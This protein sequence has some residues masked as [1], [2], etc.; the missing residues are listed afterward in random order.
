MAAPYSVNGQWNFLGT[1]MVQGMPVTT[2]I[3]NAVSADAVGQTVAVGAVTTGAPGS[4]AVVTN[5]GT[6]TSP[7]LNFTIPAGATGPAGPAGPVG[8]SPALSAGTATMLPAGSVPTIGLSTNGN[9]YAINVGVPAGTP[10]VSPTINFS[11]VTTASPGSPAAVLDTVSGSTHNISL[12]LPAGA[13]G[14][15]GAPGP[16]GVSPTLTFAPVITANPDTPAS[17]VDTLNGS[18]HTIALTIP[19]GANGA[20]GAAGA[21]GAAG[22]PGNTTAAAFATPYA[23]A[24]RSETARAAD[25]VNVVDYGA[26]GSGY[27]AQ[28]GT[29]YGSTL[30][31]MASWKAADGTTPFT[32]LTSDDYHG[33]VVHTLPLDNAQIAPGTDLNFLSSYSG[34][35]PGTWSARIAQWQRPD[36]QQVYIEGGNAWNVTVAGGNTSTC[37]IPPGTTVSSID[38]ALGD[39]N[40][41][42]ITLSAATTLACP[43]GTNITFTMSDARA[44]RIDPDWLAIESAM[45]V[46][47]QN[48][49]AGS[50][51]GA[52]ERTVM[53]PS[54]ELYPQLPL[55][56]YSWQD[57]PGHQIQI[58]GQGE[59]TSVI[60][61]LVDFGPG[62][63]GLSSYTVSSSAMRPVFR[64]FSMLGSGSMVNNAEGTMSWKMDGLCLTQSAQVDHVISNNFHAGFSWLGDHQHVTNSEAHDNLYGIYA[65]PFAGTLGNQIFENDILTGNNLASFGVASTN[66][67]DSATFTDVHTGF[68]PYGFLKEAD[69]STIVSRTGWC[70]L[71]QSTI[72]DVWAEATGNGWMYDAAGNGC[73]HDNVFIGMHGNSTIQYSNGSGGMEALPGKAKALIYTNSFNDN[74]MIGT[75]WYGYSFVTD[76]VIESTGDCTDNKIIGDNALVNNA[77]W[78]VPPMLCAGQKGGNT[79]SND[80]DGFLAPFAQFV[81]YGSPVTM[82]G[83]GTM[84]GFVTG[85]AFLGTSMDTVGVSGQAQNPNALYPVV[86]SGT[87]VWARL[88]SNSPSANVG[89]MLRPVTGGFTVVSCP[90]GV[91]GVSLT[92]TGAGQVAVMEMS[93]SM[94][95]GSCN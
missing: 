94:D 7:I 51:G 40:Y 66:Q 5:S 43:A 87:D 20:P 48:L 85:S 33:G 11:S 46:A 67:I 84:T 42:H 90:F 36:R 1:L 77:G 93:P 41:G 71:T 27:S 70:L 54:F 15:I 12:T 45:F 55:I 86:L 61:D 56:F 81:P 38:S 34:G 19:A 26:T 2:M 64:D 60:Y 44:Q 47:A 82:T 88:A 52:T 3:Q 30:A 16:A 57:G 89:S 17:V 78:T 65:R 9:A 18:T 58:K 73:V 53:L 62:K 6:G 4:Q 10:G 69:E 50:V 74:K 63:C 91:K 13:P 83:S 23:P 28:I 68:G 95:D 21:Q 32:W 29:R 92:G 31:A 72:N 8:L 14:S 39:A 59:N 37:S 24:T 76:A 25:I 49:G 35:Y 79:F 80:Q 22:A 75:G